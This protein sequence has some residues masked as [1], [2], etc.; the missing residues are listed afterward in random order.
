[1]CSIRLLQLSMPLATVAELEECNDSESA[2]HHHG[3]SH[4]GDMI[5]CFWRRTPP[6]QVFV[7][8]TP[9]KFAFSFHLSTIEK[10]THVLLCSGSHRL[11]MSRA[12][13]QECGWC[14]PISTVMDSV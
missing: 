11:V 12:M 1:M 5:A 8:Y 7:A 10:G 2:R 3:G 9:S 4:M 6:L 14:N 13:K